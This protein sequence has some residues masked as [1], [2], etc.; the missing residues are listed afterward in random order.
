MID[1]RGAGCRVLGDGL[2]GMDVVDRYTR[3]VGKQDAARIGGID[4]G[5]GVVAPQHV[6]APGEMVVG[7]AHLCQQG[8]CHIALVHPYIHGPRAGH[9]TS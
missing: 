9:S 3:G 7:Q 1:A 4:K 2:V 5:V 6:S 8:G